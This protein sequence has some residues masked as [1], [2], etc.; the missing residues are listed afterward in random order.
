MDNDDPLNDTAP[1][2]GEIQ[3]KV[4]E[5]VD[6]LSPREDESTVN[7]NGAQ[8]AAVDEADPLKAGFDLENNLRNLLDMYNTNS[9]SNGSNT[10]SYDA[11][12][13]EAVAAFNQKQQQIVTRELEGRTTAMNRVE[14]KTLEANLNKIRKLQEKERANR[15]RELR[16][17]E[18]HQMFVPQEDGA[19]HDLEMT[20]APTRREAMNDADHGLIDISDDEEDEDDRYARVNVRRRGGRASK[21]TSKTRKKPAKAAQAG[22]QKRGKATTRRGRGGHQGPSMLNMRSLIRN[23][24]VA[25]AAANQGAGELTSFAGIRT[26]KD[27]L[28]ALIA[29]IPAGQRDLNRGEKKALD[30]AAKRFAYRGRGSMQVKDDGWRLKGM[31]TSLKNFQLLG[32]AW[33]CEREAGA[34]APFGG[35]LAD[36]MGYGK[37]MQHSDTEHHELTSTSDSS[38]DYHHGRK[39]AQTRREEQNYTHRCPWQ[40]HRPVGEGNCSSY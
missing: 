14:L 31:S 33:G 10:T 29:S 13:N 4:E 28:A 12:Y 7:D 38:N 15:K 8:S 30:E 24:I 16:E 39:S 20:P 1:V 27:A 37:V 18:D 35:I 25:N 22:V 26:K 11:E 3:I 17:Q 36:T 6:E 32:A 21:A 9:N 23:D 19:Y 34:E 40:H 2:G 5:G